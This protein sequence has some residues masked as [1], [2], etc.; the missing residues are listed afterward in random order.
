MNI[1][2]TKV[3]HKVVKCSVAENK[4]H[5]LD[6]HLQCFR[7]LLSLVNLVIVKSSTRVTI[8]NATQ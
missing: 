8:A 4:I 2:I 1:Q 6:F 7:S 5:F 3:V